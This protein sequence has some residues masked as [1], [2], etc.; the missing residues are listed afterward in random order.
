MEARTAGIDMNDADI[1]SLLS[2]CKQLLLW[3]DKT[4]STVNPSYSITKYEFAIP[5]H[6]EDKSLKDNTKCEKWGSLG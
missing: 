6:F 1:T 3:Y 5:I 4:E 2:N